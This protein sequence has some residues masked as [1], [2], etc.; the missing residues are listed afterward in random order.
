MRGVSLVK[1]LISNGTLFFQLFPSEGHLRQKDEA[2]YLQLWYL[3]LCTTF[4]KSLQNK[5]NKVEICVSLSCFHNVSFH[6]HST[7]KCTLNIMQITNERVKTWEDT[8][9]STPFISTALQRATLLTTSHICHYDTIKNKP[10]YVSDLQ[11]KNLSQ[12]PICIKYIDGHI[13]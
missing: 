3:M 2:L 7:T 12:F 4:V 13:W 8:F 1:L 5:I 6:L 11:F 9:S 10:M